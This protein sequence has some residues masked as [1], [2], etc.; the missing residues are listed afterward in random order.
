MRVELSIGS[1]RYFVE[2]NHE[3]G[4]AY[5]YSNLVESFMH[6]KDLCIHIMTRKIK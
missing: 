1:L 3:R 4:W 6:K 5:C 2:Y